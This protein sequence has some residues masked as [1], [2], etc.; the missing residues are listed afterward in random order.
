[1]GYEEEVN[2]EPCVGLVYNATVNFCEKSQGHQ[3]SEMLMG[4]T[5]GNQERKSLCT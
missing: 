3:I 2:Q 1:M 5:S 4:V